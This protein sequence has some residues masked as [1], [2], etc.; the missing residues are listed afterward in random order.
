M[1]KPGAGGVIGTAAIAAA[2]PDGYTI[3]TLMTSAMM[4]APY[5]QKVPYHPV[6]DIEPIMQYGLFLFAVSVR[7]DSQFSNFKDVIAYARKNPQVVTYGTVGAAAAQQVILEQIA[8]HEKVQWTNVPYKSGSELQTALM[9][10]DIM[11]VAGD[12]L[13]AMVEAKKQRLLAM[14]LNERS[15]VYPDVPTL[16]ELGYLVP[17]PYFMGIGAPKGIPESVMSKLNDA[18]T[19]AFNDQEFAEGMKSLGLPAFYRNRKEFGSYIAEN[20]AEIGRSM[21]HQSKK[22]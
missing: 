4:T 20:Y 3:G 15:S 7:G 1:N 10:G 13:P 18:F 12:F 9:A 8:R 14:F 6:A 11:L 16:R 17:F 21:E 22:E 5:V 19:K 2:N